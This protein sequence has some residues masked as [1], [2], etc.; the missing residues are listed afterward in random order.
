VTLIKDVPVAGAEGK[1]LYV[2]FDAPIGYISLQ[3]NGLYEGK[4]WE[5]YWKIKTPKLVHFIGKTIS[6]SLCDFP[7]DVKAEGSFILPDNVPANEFL[8]LEINYL[9][10]KTGQFGCTNI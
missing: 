5:P 9:R 4:D 3:K 2:W 1:K 8:N 10:L 7:C 6:F